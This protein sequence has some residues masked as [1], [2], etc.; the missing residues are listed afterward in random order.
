M[1]K[2]HLLRRLGKRKI[3][4]LDRLAATIKLRLM[5][6]RD[7]PIC[8]TGPEGEGKSV[9][10]IQLSRRVDDNFK[11]TRNV[12]FAPTV[13]Q[14]DKFFKE[15]PPYSSP[16]FDEFGEVGYKMDF[17][18]SLSKFL[19]KLFM[20]NRQS[21]MAPIFCI[22]NFL[23][24]DKYYRWR[25]KLLLFVYKRGRFV[26]FKPLKYNVF[27][28]DNWQTKF[29]Q[30]VWDTVT[31]G[32][33]ITNDTKFLKVVRKWT[34][35]RGEGTFDKLPGLLSDEYKRL[36]NEYY[37]NSEKSTDF[38]ALQIK[39]SKK[40][41]LLKQFVACFSDWGVSNRVLAKML[42]LT[43]STI[44]KYAKTI[45]EKGFSNCFHQ[46]VVTIIQNNKMHNKAYLLNSH[47]VN[48]KN[49][50]KAMRVMLPKGFENKAKTNNPKDDKKDGEEV[51]L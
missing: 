10:G 42:E 48:S 24:M 19:K 26:A 35:Y 2:Y 41:I 44:S 25:I 30:A 14:A 9:L 23:D 47:L 37:I 13:E 32:A 12:M 17:A 1:I 31:K 20:K 36:K 8:I 7:Y 29:N 45:P 27:S 33:P 51:S 40:T 6:D 15:E 16:Q 50:V 39:E 43:D 49:R 46:S 5:E 18:T 28:G 21:N 4:K 34:I 3:I 38:E 11:L 22:P